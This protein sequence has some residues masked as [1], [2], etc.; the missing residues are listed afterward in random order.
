MTVIRSNALIA[1][2][3]N[4]TRHDLLPQDIL[5]AAVADLAVEAGDLTAVSRF[6][7]TPCF[8]AGAGPDYVNAVVELETDLSAS[9]LLERLHGIEA[10]HA[11]KRVQRWGM[12][13]LDLDLLS[14]DDR[15]LPDARSYGHW[16]DLPL[17]RQMQEAPDQLILPHPRLQDRA[18]VLVPL[19]DIA[20]GWC[21]PVLKKTAAE[22]RDALPKSE[23]DSV[24]ALY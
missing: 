7:R 20:P 12:R 10:R 9:A 3:G 8:P 24:I 1:L 22:M 11:R 5:A 23:I 21:H 2:G 19:C 4:L 17:E 6:F 13:T 16:R 15:V 18:F 14:F